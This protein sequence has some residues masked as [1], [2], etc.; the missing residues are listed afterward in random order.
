MHFDQKRPF[1]TRFQVFFADFALPSRRGPVFI[2]FQKLTTKESKANKIVICQDKIIAPLI[3]VS[4][5]GRKASH[6]WKSILRSPSCPP[7]APVSRKRRALRL[8]GS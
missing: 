1:S 7:R 5:S 2:L 4:R 8:P 3:R 6:L